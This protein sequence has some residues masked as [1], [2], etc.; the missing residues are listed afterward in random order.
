MVLL[1]RKSPKPQMSLRLFLALTTPIVFLVLWC[2]IPILIPIPAFGN[3]LLQTL[4]DSHQKLWQKDHSDFA[5]ESAI[6]K[7]LFPSGSTVADAESKMKFAFFKCDEI[8]NL[9]A[10][11]WRITHFHPLAR[12]GWEVTLSLDAAGTI[13]N[14]EARQYYEG[15]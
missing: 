8:V 11:C 7:Q 10:S 1:E 3:A 2:F 14:A 13:T 15:L 6:V 4:S 9:S 12:Y 5:V